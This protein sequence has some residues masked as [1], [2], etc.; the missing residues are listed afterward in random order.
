M[1]SPVMVWLHGG[2]FSSG[3]GGD[4]ITEGE[5]LA[6]KGDVVVVSVNHRLNVFGYLQI[7]KAWGPG[8][9]AP[10]QQDSHSSSTCSF[11]KYQK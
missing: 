5:N 7:S 9:A 6:R 2:G 8:K 4:A 1:G 3:S 10:D 11:L